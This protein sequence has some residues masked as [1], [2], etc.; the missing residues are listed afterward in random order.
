ME[1]KI[2]D[3][4]ESKEGGVEKRIFVKESNLNALQ[5]DL[6]LGNIVGAYLQLPSEIRAKF[7]RHLKCDCGTSVNSKC[8]FC[9]NE[10]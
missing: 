5:K 9:N 1:E 7:H 10:L 6:L 3:F 8:W 2:F 4:L